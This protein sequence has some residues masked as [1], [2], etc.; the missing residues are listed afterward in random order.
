MSRSILPVLLLNKCLIRGESTVHERKQTAVLHARTLKHLLNIFATTMPFICRLWILF[1]AILIYELFLRPACSSMTRLINSQVSKQDKLYMFHHLTVQLLYVITV[2]LYAYSLK[3]W[4]ISWRGDSKVFE[5]LLTSL[6]C[7]EY[8]IL[9][10][11][12]G[13]ASQWECVII[14]KREL[15]LPN[16]SIKRNRVRP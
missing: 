12:S 4:C 11:P 10:G 8:F 1:I 3:Y 16:I 5:W 13:T 15:R 6:L 9:F 7:K 2:Q 14:S